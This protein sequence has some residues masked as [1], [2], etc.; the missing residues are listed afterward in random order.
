MQTKL[1]S[2][3]PKPTN[4]AAAEAWPSIAS[5]K[6][7]L[8]VHGCK[9]V[10][11]DWTSVSLAEIFSNRMSTLLMFS[12]WSVTDIYPAP[13]VF[14]QVLPRKVCCCRRTEFITWKKKSH[15]CVTQHRLPFAIICKVL[16]SF[17]INRAIDHRG[18]M[19]RGPYHSSFYTAEHFSGCTLQTAPCRQLLQHTAAKSSHLV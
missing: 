13:Q 6:Q 3:I 4:V 18:L 11:V 15:R 12:K 8:S 16:K 9:K 14:C 7:I 1:T 10:C 19:V 2:E 5:L 17:K